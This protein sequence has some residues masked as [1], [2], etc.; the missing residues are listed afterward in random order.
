MEK[1]YSYAEFMKVVG[2]NRSSVYAEKLLNEIYMDMFL[3]RLHREQTRGRI[4]K[5]IDDALDHRDE[6][7]FHLYAEKLSDFREVK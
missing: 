2:R 5:L 4:V 1:K 6:Q 3:N 7:K